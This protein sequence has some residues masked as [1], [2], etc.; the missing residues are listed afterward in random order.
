MTDR[1]L[2]VSRVLLDALVLILYLAGQ[3]GFAQHPDP[4]PTDGNA[5]A[6]TDSSALQR[7][8]AVLD[9]VS[10]IRL[11]GQLLLN[12]GFPLGHRISPYIAAREDGVP[13]VQVDYHD[14]WALATALRKAQG[15]DRR[16][17]RENDGGSVEATSPGPASPPLAMLWRSARCTHL[18]SGWSKKISRSRYRALDKEIDVAAVTTIPLRYSRGR[19]FVIRLMA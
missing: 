10:A 11:P 1:R 3:S 2:T 5:D 18:G 14:F 6:V 7:H 8:L 13:T 16:L 12:R 17:A 4:A 9:S 15:T 19:F